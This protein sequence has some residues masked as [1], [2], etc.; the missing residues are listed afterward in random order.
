MDVEELV[1]KNVGFLSLDAEVYRYCEN[2]DT[3]YKVFTDVGGDKYAIK[4]AIA[5]EGSDGQIRRE[6]EEMF[7]EHDVTK[8]S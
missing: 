4:I 3:I 8:L 7:E 2:G 6:V 1:D 5:S